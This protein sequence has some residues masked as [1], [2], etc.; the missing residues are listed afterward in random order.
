MK[1][2]FYPLFLS[3][4]VSSSLLAIPT[5]I[6]W[7]NT[8]PPTCCK[9]LLLTLLPQ[10]E[11]QVN[12][13]YSNYFSK[14]PTTAQYV[15]DIEQ[16]EKTPHTSG[17]AYTLVVSVEPY[18]GPHNTIGRDLLT[19][20][21]GINGAHFRSFNHVASYPIPDKYDEYILKPLP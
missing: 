20:D 10:I 19:F 18:F 8:A 3:L 11:Q 4:L 12:L 1:R 16:L 2:I 13:Y 6:D 14:V 5:K 17:Y 15:T 9:A 21:I 7:Y